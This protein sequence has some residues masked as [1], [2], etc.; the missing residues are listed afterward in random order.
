MLASSRRYLQCSAVH[1]IGIST[2]R[3]AAG[4]AA[5]SCG[6]ARA[7]LASDA[8]PASQSRKEAELQDTGG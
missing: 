8:M 3:A 7:R 6:A 4:G 2:L 5:F 1:G